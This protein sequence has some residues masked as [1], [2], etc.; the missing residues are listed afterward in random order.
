[1]DGAQRLSN[2]DFL[3]IKFIFLKSCFF[4]S[5]LCHTVIGP[6]NLIVV[7]TTR[8]LYLQLLAIFVFSQQAVAVFASEVNQYYA[9]LP[10]KN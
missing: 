1:M 2:T 3:L 6:V 4:L 8:T 7:S 5:Y 9:P 10:V